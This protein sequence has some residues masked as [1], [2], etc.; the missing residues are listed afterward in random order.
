MGLGLNPLLSI[1]SNGQRDN[2]RAV[3]MSKVDTGRGWI[4]K[5]EAKLH[6]HKRH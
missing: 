3:W 6:I 1:L 5:V 2:R 4:V